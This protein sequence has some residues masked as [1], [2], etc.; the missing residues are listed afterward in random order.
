MSPA[1]VLDEPASVMRWLALENLGRGEAKPGAVMP[2]A[3]ESIEA[4]IPMTLLSGSSEG[5]RRSQ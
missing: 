2:A 3:E 5:F 1:A 4:S